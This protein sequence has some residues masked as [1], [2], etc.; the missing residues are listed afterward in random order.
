MVE[1]KNFFNFLASLG[2]SSIKSFVF[3]VKIEYI[4]HVHYVIFTTD[5]PRLFS[6]LFIFVYE[7]DL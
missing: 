4:N 5:V 1:I 3:V 2:T 7:T 6:N